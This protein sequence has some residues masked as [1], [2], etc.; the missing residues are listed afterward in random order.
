MHA[1]IQLAHAWVNPKPAGG[2]LCVIFFR[3]FF[4]GIG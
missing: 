4:P 1:C 3:P 2:L